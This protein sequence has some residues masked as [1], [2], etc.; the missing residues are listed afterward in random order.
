MH[1]SNHCSSLAAS[2]IPP[3]PSTRHCATSRKRNWNWNVRNSR[4]QTSWKGVSLP[5]EKSS[6]GKRRLCS[7]KSKVEVVRN[8]RSLT[9]SRLKW[10]DWSKPSKLVVR[11]LTPAWWKTP[12][13]SEWSWP[14]RSSQKNWSSS[15]GRTFN[16]CQRKIPLSRSTKASYPYSVASSKIVWNSRKIRHPHRARPRWTLSLQ[17]QRRTKKFAKLED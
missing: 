9:I 15:A 14:E 13:S 7:P 11:S 6:T 4:P 12:T 1:I 5:S 10:Q 8:S 17:K 2:E 3:N 16:S